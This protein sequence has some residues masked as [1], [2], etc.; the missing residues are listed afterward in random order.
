M[1]TGNFINRDTFRINCF[2]NAQR[3]FSTTSVAGIVR[4]EIIASYARYYNE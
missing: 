3:T 4:V 2:L 1:H